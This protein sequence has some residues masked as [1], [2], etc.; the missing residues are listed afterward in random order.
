VR[1]VPGMEW[2]NYANGGCIFA[3]PHPDP[4]PARSSMGRESP[5]AVP[6]AECTN[7]VRQS[8]RILHDIKEGF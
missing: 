6:A 3:M 7:G 1:P 5:W 8:N 2:D 4:N